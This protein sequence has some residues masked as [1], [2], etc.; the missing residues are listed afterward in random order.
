[1]ARPQR[2]R[3]ASS[4]EEIP[5]HNRI[6]RAQ[7]QHNRPYFIRHRS[8]QPHSRHPAQHHFY[9]VFGRRQNIITENPRQV[10]Q[11]RREQAWRVMEREIRERERV[12][13]W[14]PWSREEN[15]RDHR[16]EAHGSYHVEFS[17]YSGQQQRARNGNHRGGIQIQG[18]HPHLK[19]QHG[20]SY[21]YGYVN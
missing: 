8:N 7:P 13:A 18:N 1:M 11:F 4:I 19:C 12:A 17:P 21:W 20:H 6:S 3:F 5:Q 2:V 16:S 14:N 9:D 15:T 10:E